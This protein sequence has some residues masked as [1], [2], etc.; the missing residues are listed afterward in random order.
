[1]ARWIGLLLASAACASCGLYR[2]STDELRN[3]PH[4]ALIWAARTGHVATIQRLAAAGLDLDDSSRTSLTFIF[5]DFD[6][7]AW[8]ALQHAVAKGQVEAVRVLLE[9]GADPDAQRDGGTPLFI[10]ASRND[11]T[12]LRL[13]LD[14]GADLS[15][16]KAWTETPAAKNDGEL[17]PVMEAALARAHA[18][19]S[20]TD[21]SGRTPATPGPSRP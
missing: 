19:A 16:T 1:M 21:A 5:P 12:S 17:W 6:H 8:T 7:F 11:M 10:A 15:V 20:P 14:A 18:S 2:P 13:L 3:N 4:G 9:W